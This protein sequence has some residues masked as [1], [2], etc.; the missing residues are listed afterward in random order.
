MGIQRT[1]NLSLKTRFSGPVQRQLAMPGKRPTRIQN[2]GDRIQNKVI[3]FG[4]AGKYKMYNI[5][6]LECLIYF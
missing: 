6:D 2:S 3:A 1:Y 5:G 4:L